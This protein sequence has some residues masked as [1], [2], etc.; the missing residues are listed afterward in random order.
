MKFKRLQM[1]HSLR[2]TSLKGTPFI[3]VCTLCGTQGLTFKN[4]SDECPN[5]RGLSQ[6]E[7]LIEAIKGGN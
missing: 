5:Q 2:R 1:K 6:D 7:D 3:G 4:M